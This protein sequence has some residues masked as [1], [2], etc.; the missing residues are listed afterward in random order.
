MIINDKCLIPLCNYG[1]CVHG[2][3]VKSPV[4]FKINMLTYTDGPALS[5]PEVY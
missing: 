2:L 4:P 3:P 5:G 1:I